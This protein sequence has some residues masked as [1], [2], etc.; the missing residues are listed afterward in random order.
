MEAARG[1]LQNHVVCGFFLVA[2]VFG[3]LCEDFPDV[4]V[5]Y[6]IPESKELEKRRE[7]LGFRFSSTELALVPLC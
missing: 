1:P 3:D 6:Y 4:D 5:L 7:D 2:S